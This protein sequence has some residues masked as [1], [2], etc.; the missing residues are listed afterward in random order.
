MLSFLPTL[1]TYHCDKSD[2][3][4][5]DSLVYRAI[6]YP[7]DRFVALFFYKLR[8]Q[9]FLSGLYECTYSMLLIRTEYQAQSGAVGQLASRLTSLLFV[10]LNAPEVISSMSTTDLLQTSIRSFDQSKVVVGTC[11]I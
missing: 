9:P 2:A 11:C 1:L 4:N 6:L 8:I 5:T 7:G 3:E 10:Q